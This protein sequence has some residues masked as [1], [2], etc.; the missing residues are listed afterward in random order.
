MSRNACKITNAFNYFPI[1]GFMI[2][3][4]GNIHRNHACYKN[5]DSL[6]RIFIRQL[7]TD[8]VMN[9]LADYMHDLSTCW[10]ASTIGLNGPKVPK[11]S[12]LL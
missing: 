11:T 6:L 7:K 12:A 4:N 9:H 5:Q 8:L 3:P 10:I 2:M 1:G